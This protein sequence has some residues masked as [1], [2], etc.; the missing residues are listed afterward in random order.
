MTYINNHRSADARRRNGII[1]QTQRYLDTL[2]NWG[3]YRDIN[4]VEEIPERIAQVT[5]A[6]FG[7]KGLAE[8]RIRLSGI[9]GTIILLHMLEQV[10]G[11]VATTGMRLY[12]RG[13][14]VASYRGITIRKS[15]FT[16]KAAQALDQ[17]SGGRLSVT[18]GYYFF[19]SGRTWHCQSLTLQF[20]GEVRTLTR[21]HSFSLPQREFFFDRPAVV[22]GD[23]EPEEGERIISI[24]RIIDLVKGDEL[25]ETIPGFIGSI[26]ELESLTILRPIKYL[27]FMINWLLIDPAERDHNARPVDYETILKGSPPGGA[28]S[29]GLYQVARPPSG[30]PTTGLWPSTSRTIPASPP[31]PPPPPPPPY[32]A[33]LFGAGPPAGSSPANGPTGPATPA[34]RYPDRIRIDNRDY[35]LV[36]KRLVA[37]PLNGGQ[38]KVD[39]IYYD[40]WVGRWCDIV[41]EETRISLARAVEAGLVSIVDPAYWPAT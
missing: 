23:R 7:L 11:G 34:A 19:E 37:S 36:I 21:L 32:E 14:P 20:G 35:P 6:Y 39:A 15:P 22:P 4:H 13:K 31:P 17:V 26:N 1:G 5:A 33:D 27:L 18:D 29:S 10:T 16:L 40:D 41:D 2:G 24:Q 3:T 38:R 25:P 28:G 9:L 12:A 8:G 30:P